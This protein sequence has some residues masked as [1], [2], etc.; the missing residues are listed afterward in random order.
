MVLER[1]NFETLK[2]IS[3]QKRRIGVLHSVHTAHRR[4]PGRPKFIAL[5]SGGA[6]TSFN[7]ERHSIS[8]L[9]CFKGCRHKCFFGCLYTK[10]TFYCGKV[11]IIRVLNI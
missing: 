4:E 7:F 2:A 5:L 9:I 3:V 11:S 1:F 8:K 6:S 10:F